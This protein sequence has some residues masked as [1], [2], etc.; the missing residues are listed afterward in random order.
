MLDHS[1]FITLTDNVD[2][3]DPEIAGMDM[4]PIM[5]VV[6][7]LYGQ[8]PK[9]TCLPIKIDLRKISPAEVSDLSLVDPV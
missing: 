5:N 8:D 7:A 6:S 1:P 9:V 2:T 4:L 3:A